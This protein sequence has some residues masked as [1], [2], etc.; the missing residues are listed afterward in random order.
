MID[1]H[2]KDEHGSSIEHLRAA[3]AGALED[4]L[5]VEQA[6]Q[7]VEPAP[8]PLP[9]D[10]P[11]TELQGP[12]RFSESLLWEW[13]RGFFDGQGHKAWSDGIVPHY[14]TSSSY[15]SKAYANVVF[16][17]LRDLAAQG[18]EEPVYFVEL[19][20][21]SG[22]FAFHFL[23][24]L[25]SLFQD[26]VLEGVISWRYVLTDF[27][28]QNLDFWAHHPSFAPYVEAG[29]LDW[30]LFDCTRPAPLRLQISGAVLEPTFA[31]RPIV[32]IANYL[33]DTIPQ[34]LFWVEQQTLQECH[35]A[36]TVTGEVP[37][38]N[39]PA[40]I[41]AVQLHYDQHPISG[42]V[43]EQPLWNQLLAEY[44][45]T[46]DASAVLF[47]HHGLACLEYL[48]ALSGNALLLLSGDKGYSLP[49][50]L[51]FRPLP[52]ITRH[53]SFSM[54][55]NYHAIGRWFELNNGFVLHTNEP[56]H[57]INIC[58]CLLDGSDDY[59]ETEQAF[60]QHIEGFGPDQQF[61]LKRAI[62]RNYQLLKPAEVL[63]YVRL[64]GYDPKAFRRGLPSLSSQAE[65]F[66]HAL[67]QQLDN[68]VVT[69]W[70]NYFPLG[71]QPDIAFSTAILLYELDMYHR[72]TEFFEQSLLLYGPDPGTHCNLAMCHAQLGNRQQAQQH[73][74]AALQLDPQHAG[75][76]ELQEQLPT[77]PQLASKSME[78]VWP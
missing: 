43:Y 74:D 47:P 53:G 45:A 29:L 67:K 30:A 42:N 46:L 32:A 28:Q 41:E 38:A 4:E 5:Q 16:G 35:V 75:T 68:V 72:A 14:L 19:G 69:M 39:N 7:P 15:I 36:L 21:G 27:T 10:A 66:T 9:E 50:E 52:G 64:S 6:H 2:A 55:V 73:M 18:V 26:S 3:M 49:S 24:H 44:T 23:Q 48:A 31:N 61:V 78:T 33:F 58:C 70:R 12:T 25:S 62:E 22:Q 60:A 77:G 8:S 34:D 40:L 76:L 54:S 11:I 56:H 20:A 63:A 71:E 59:C 1:I 51:A 57:S 37:D 17:H 13:Q 65:D